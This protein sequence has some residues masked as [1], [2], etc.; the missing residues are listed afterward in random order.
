LAVSDPAIYFSQAIAVDAAGDLYVATANG[1]NRYA[2]A[3]GAYSAGTSLTSF[4]AAGVGAAMGPDGTLYLIAGTGSAIDKYVRTSTPALTFASTDDGTTSAAQSVVVENDGNAA[5]LPAAVAASSS[6][7]VVAGSGSPTDCLLAGTVA[8]GANCNLSVAF[9]P[10]GTQNGTVTGTAALTDNNLNGINVAQ[11]VQLSG[12]AAAAPTVTGI[13][14]ASGQAS[15]GT[16]VMITGTFF[17]G[18]TAVSFGTSAAASFTVNSATSITAVSPAGAGTVDVTVTTPT[19]TSA[20]TSGDQFLYTGTQAISFTP[21][22]SVTFGVATITLTATGGASGN[23]VTFTVVSGPGSLSG[24]TLTVTGAGNIM[25]AANQAGSSTYAAAATV[26]ATILVNKATPTLSWATPTPITYGTPLS[27]T[28]LNATA[29]V[30]GTS[31]VYSPSSGVLPAGPQTLSVTFTPTDTADYNAATATVTLT[32]N[33]ATPTLSWATPA[34]ISPGTALS[35]TQL[36]ATSSVAGTFVYT[37]AA[38]SMPA[39]GTDTL[40]VI[41]TPTD[42]TDYTT[43][44]ATVQLAVGKATP[45]IVWA[46]PAPIIYGTALS[47]AQLDATANVPGSF[48]YV[49]TLGTKPA[50]GTVTLSVTFTPTDSADYATATANVPLSV[51]QATPAVL[52]TTS[53]NP[54]LFE[55]SL[56]LTATVTSPAG[57]P[58]GSVTFLDGSTVL[59]TGI[60]VNGAVSLTTAN[61]AVGTHALTALYSGDGDF[62]SQTSATLAQIVND[63]SLSLSSSNGSPQTTGPGGA[64]YFYFML[65]PGSGA[66]LAAPVS[67]TVTGLPAGAVA[68]FN[69]QVVP[70]GSG[71]TSVGLTV[72][73]PNQ[74]AALRRPS[75]LDRRLAPLMV[76]LLLLPFGR[77]TR[78]RSR[79]MRRLGCVLLLAATGLASSAALAGCGAGYIDRTQQQT[80]TL[81]VT[82]TAGNLSRSTTVTLNVEDLLR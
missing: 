38:G 79:R 42:A 41:F 46:T 58:T 18:A 37:P 8:T 26:T 31:F 55:S 82:A 40:S 39:T 81:T 61:L 33:K 25:I 10:T 36:N 11:T 5:L 27:S 9:A 80:Y 73:V 12:T 21:P 30:A 78:H 45:A 68:T 43:A 75:G 56:V 24:N 22:S 35:S 67:F 17:T 74:V 69:P 71:T 66:A 70:A 29:S 57:S 13:S 47:T 54:V 48:V 20:P 76:A 63:F 23:P 77:K 15:G 34:P 2:Y 72:Q 50:P 53:S 3:N 44:T 65:N 4:T 14:P 16:S 28:Q 64:A 1:L 51:T 32:V 7:T 60:V 6:F 49:P 59:G 62:L 52:L 19:G